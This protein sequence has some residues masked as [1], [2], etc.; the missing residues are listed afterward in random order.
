VPPEEDEA[1][2][3]QADHGVPEHAERD[4]DGCGL[5][6]CEREN[7]VNGLEDEHR[8]VISPDPP[9]NLHALR[10]HQS[11]GGCRQ[12]ERRRGER[13][14]VKLGLGLCGPW[15]WKNAIAA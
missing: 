9:A 2:E 3:R 13:R 8:Y 11:G 7:A 6:A 10:A 15:T 1:R 4:D 5:S 14:D 12:E